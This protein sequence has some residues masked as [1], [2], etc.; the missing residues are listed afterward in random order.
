MAPVA[1]SGRLVLLHGSVVG[2]RATWA[3]QRR[4]SDEFALEL[5]LRRG[6]PPGSDVVRVDFEDDSLPVEVSLGESP[7]IDGLIESYEL[8]FRMQGELPKVLDLSKE[9]ATTLKM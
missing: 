5:P 4:L 2:P 3:A 6:F 1:G 8:A 9:T 7:E